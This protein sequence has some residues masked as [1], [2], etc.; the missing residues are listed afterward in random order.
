M[1]SVIHGIIQVGGPFSKA[2]IK[3]FMHWG[4]V[5]GILKLVEN[6]M[7]LGH[8]CVKRGAIRVW[9]RFLKCGAVRPFFNGAACEVGEC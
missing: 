8:M 4:Q 5:V 1:N 3:V 7:K 2:F 9:G 6:A